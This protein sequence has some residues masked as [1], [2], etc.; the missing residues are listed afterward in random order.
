MN[1]LSEY[2]PWKNDEDITDKNATD[3]LE[4]HNCKNPPSILM[5][6]AVPPKVSDNNKLDFTIQLYVGGLSVIGLLILF[7]L[8]NK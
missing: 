6:E 3:L 5:T 4:Y 2:T 1:P 8:L 7:R